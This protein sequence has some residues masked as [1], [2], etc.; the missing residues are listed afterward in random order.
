VREGFEFIDGALG[1]DYRAKRQ[2]NLEKKEKEGKE[3]IKTNAKKPGSNGE[4]RERA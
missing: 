1:L 3:R 4:P 2:N